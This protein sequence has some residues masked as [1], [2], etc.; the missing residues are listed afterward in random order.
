MKRHLYRVIAFT[1]IVALLAGCI[2]TR[3]PDGTTTRQPDHQAILIAET[4]LQEALNA[5]MT[6]VWRP[7]ADPVE[8]QRLL[9]AVVRWRAIVARI[10]E[11]YQERGPPTDDRTLPG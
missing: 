2:T 10:R 1:A 6:Y 7:D 4:A 9:D 11:Y 5:Y 3:Y 8:R